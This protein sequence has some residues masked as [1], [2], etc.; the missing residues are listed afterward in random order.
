LTQTPTIAAVRILRQQKRAR[1]AVRW[2]H[3]RLVHPGIRHDE[4]KPVLDDQHVAA[5]PHDANRLRQ[6]KLD[7]PRVLVDLRRKRQRLGGRLDGREVDHATFGLRNNFLRDDNNVSGARRDV[8]AHKRRR[9]EF[10][11]V[12][13]GPNE[14]KALERNDLK[15][16][17]ALLRVSSGAPTRR[18]T[19]G[20]TCSA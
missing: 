19:R 3:V 16:G 12:V 20:R 18:R 15:R 7:K 13:A 2:S 10:D 8:V 9:N 1:Q 11:Q 6:D 14:R 4:A 17:H 5:R